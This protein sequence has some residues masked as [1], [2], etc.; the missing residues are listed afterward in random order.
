MF[1]K[2]TEFI[3]TFTGGGTIPK[4]VKR[5]GKH[6]QLFSSKRPSEKMTISN[7][8]VPYGSVSSNGHVGG[9]RKV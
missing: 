1:L 4:A 6:L 5:N 2:L 3:L 9:D 8:R 7:T